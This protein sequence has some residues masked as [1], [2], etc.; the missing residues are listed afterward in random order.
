MLTVGSATHGGSLEF[1][2]SLKEAHQLLFL[3]SITASELVTVSAASKRR[4]RMVV[5]VS[6]WICSLH[7]KL[8]MSLIFI[9]D[10]CGTL[11]ISWLI[12]VRMLVGCQD[13]PQYRQH[14]IE[15]EEDNTHTLSVTH[16]SLHISPLILQLLV[17][18]LTQQGEGA[19][20]IL[21]HPLL[22]RQ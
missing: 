9:A 7:K 6:V 17:S 13:D 14:T 19:V 16:S 5:G 4:R 20:L 11:I 21:I 8:N 2:W 15:R 10:G 12:C 3:S 18:L 22:C 1:Q